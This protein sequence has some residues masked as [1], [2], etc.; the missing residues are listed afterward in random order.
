ML[1]NFVEWIVKVV[2]QENSSASE[3]SIN[4][5]LGE[6]LWQSIATSHNIKTPAHFSEVTDGVDNSNV[7]NSFCV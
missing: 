5:G 7:I 6:H 4:E 3:V 2:N 1:Y